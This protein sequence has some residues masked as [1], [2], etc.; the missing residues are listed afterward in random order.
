MPRERFFKPFYSLKIILILLRK[1]KN[2]AIELAYTYKEIKTIK[3]TI[4]NGF[5]MTIEM[6]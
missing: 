5:K 4:R 1:A 6:D 3:A 2:A